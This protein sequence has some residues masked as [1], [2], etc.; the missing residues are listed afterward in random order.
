MLS[1]VVNVAV[2]LSKLFDR[3]VSVFTDVVSEAVDVSKLFARVV[4]VAVEEE[5]L[6]RPIVVAAAVEFNVD[7]IVAVEESRLSTLVLRVP[8]AVETF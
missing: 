5:R 2:L 1:R 6:F 8:V 4:N 7:K 3:V